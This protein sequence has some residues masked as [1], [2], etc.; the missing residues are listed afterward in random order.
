VALKHLKWL[1]YLFVGRLEAETEQQYWN[2][3]RK[4]HLAIEHSEGVVSGLGV[5]E[6]APPS[7]SIEVTAGRALD[8]DG[9]DPEIESLQQIDCAGLV[10]SSGEIT[11]YIALYY[12]TVET[13]PYFVD[14]IGDY[15]NKFIQD[16]YVLE[17]V[18]QAPS[19]PEI[20]LARFQLGAGATEITDAVDPDN[21]ALNEI[22]LRY[23]KH[24]GKEITA[25]GDLADVSANEADAFNGMDSPSAVRH[26]LVGASDVQDALDGA[27]SPGSGNPFATLADTTRQAQV[28]GLVNTNDFLTLNHDFGVI[29]TVTVLKNVSG[30]WVDGLASGSLVLVDAAIARIENLAPSAVEYLIVATV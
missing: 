20:E 2:E 25:L 18:T 19:S 4:K 5:S 22:D 23:V 3:K 29:P 9:H 10:P 14:E 11:V 30:D 6:T 21:P 27:S 12:N 28:S 26:I 7:L 24:S 8:T 17:A 13:D 1:K 16:S 15:Q